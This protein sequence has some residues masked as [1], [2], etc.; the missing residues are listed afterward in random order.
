MKSLSRRVSLIAVLTATCIVTNYALVGVPNVAVMD[1]IVFVAGYGFGFTVGAV[2]GAFTWIIYGFINPY[3]TVLPIW[4]AT[5]VSEA[6]YSAFG[7]FA[8]RIN[9][10][11]NN[12][13]RGKFLSTNLRF[14]LIG[15]LSTLAY[16]LA[17]NAVFGL[18]FYGG[19]ITS[20]FIAIAAGVYFSTVHEISNALIFFA[21]A[22]PLIKVVEVLKR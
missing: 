8:R 15:F 20:I 18:T 17:T 2:I 7:S 16:D 1:M 22:V 13:S 5:I 9:L 19:T 14:A 11:G 4:I 21:G 3:G 6:V 12:P 10:A